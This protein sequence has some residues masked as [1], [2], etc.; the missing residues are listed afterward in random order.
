VDQ[1]VAGACESTGF[2][3]MKILTVPSSNSGRSIGDV[4]LAL[5]ST[6]HLARKSTATAF[7]PHTNHAEV[8]S[9]SGN[10]WT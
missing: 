8:V 2:S 7:L 9:F 4:F 10:P 5:L 3:P 1:R 6:V